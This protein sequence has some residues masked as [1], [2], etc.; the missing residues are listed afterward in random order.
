MTKYQTDYEKENI[1]EKALYFKFTQHPNLRRMLLATG[2]KKLLFIHPEDSFW[3][4]G[5]TK[6]LGL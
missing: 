3:G 4:T 6:S 1:M 5:T 2:T